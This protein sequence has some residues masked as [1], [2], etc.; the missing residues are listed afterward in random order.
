MILKNSSIVTWRDM[1]SWRDIE[2][3]RPRAAELRKII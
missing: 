3:V 1:T 2:R